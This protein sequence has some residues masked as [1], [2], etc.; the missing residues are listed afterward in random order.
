MRYGLLKYFCVVWHYSSDCTITSLHVPIQWRT[1]GGGGGG[2]GGQTPPPIEDFKRNENLSFRNKPPFFI[3][4]LPKLL[5]CFSVLSNLLYK[6][7]KNFHCDAIIGL[8]M[9][10]LCLCAALDVDDCRES[11]TFFVFKAKSFLRTVTV[12]GAGVSGVRTG[13]FGG[14][15]PLH[16][17]LKKK[18]KPLF[19]K[20]SAFFHA[21]SAEIAINYQVFLC[22]PTS[23]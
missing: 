18:W 15:P 2:F 5:S 17:R 20:R 4:R 7:L 10:K 3:Q 11:E 19:L 21:K 12:S 13:G 22:Y 14:Q 16:W 9:V 6:I 8:L 23:Q 1:H